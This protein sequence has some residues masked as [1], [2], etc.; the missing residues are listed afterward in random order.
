[1]Q[2]RQQKHAAGNWIHS[3]VRLR[4]RSFTLRVGIQKEFAECKRNTVKKREDQGKSPLEL[5]RRL[6]DGFQ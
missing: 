2:R 3:K 5:H 1:M 6:E 4:I